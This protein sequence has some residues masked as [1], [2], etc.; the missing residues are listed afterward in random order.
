MA[1]T[2]T[3]FVISVPDA[4]YGKRV[5]DPT[6]AT[7]TAEVSVETLAEEETISLKRYFLT[8]LKL[9]FGVRY[10]TTLTMSVIPTYTH[11]LAIHLLAVVS[12]ETLEWTV[13]DVSYLRLTT[14]G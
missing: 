9:L 7:M 6:V 2:E 3:P 14:L 10:A 8:A 4:Q 12:Y 5:S 11:F 13:D 1:I